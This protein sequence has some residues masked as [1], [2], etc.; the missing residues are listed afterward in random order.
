MPGVSC[1]C[2]SIG[3][4][5]HTH[6]VVPLPVDVAEHGQA[7]VKKVRH[8][9]DGVKDHQEDEEP[10]EPDEARWIRAALLASSF[11]PAQEGL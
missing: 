7:V 2:G 3:P 10:A 4:H 5:T 9:E 1:S 6:R 8:Q 11:V